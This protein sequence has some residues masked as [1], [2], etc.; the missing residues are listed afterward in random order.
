[1]QRVY[2]RYGA[3]QGVSEI[4]CSAE[5]IRDTMQCRVS[6]SDKNNYFFATIIPGRAFV[7]TAQRLCFVR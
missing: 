6:V 3:M 1:M 5:C 4:R 2:Q 7:H